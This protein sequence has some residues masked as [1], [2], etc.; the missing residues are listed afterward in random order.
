MSEDLAWAAGLADGEGC[1]SGTFNARYKFVSFEFSVANTN[2]AAVEEFQRIVGTGTVKRSAMIKAGVS[3]RPIYTWR[4]RGRKAQASAHLLL[5]WLRIK[6]P[7]ATFLQQVSI[8][9]RGGKRPLPI[10]YKV[11]QAVA[12]AR[13]KELN[14]V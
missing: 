1:I 5:P 8:L 13:L 11:A 9:P 7:Q 4:A 10:F 14:H 3:Y 12:C 6:K 2:L